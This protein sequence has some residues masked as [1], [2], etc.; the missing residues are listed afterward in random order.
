MIYNF[1]PS[2]LLLDLQKTIGVL[3]PG[4]SKYS[5]DET[6][7]TIGALATHNQERSD[8]KV[9]IVMQLSKFVRKYFS[10]SYFQLSNFVVVC[11]FAMPSTVSL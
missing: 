8:V 9:E 2:L 6:L 3:S 5:L 4:E 1:L 11:S 7:G 10:S